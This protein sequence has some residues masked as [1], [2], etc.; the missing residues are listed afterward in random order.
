MKCLLPLYLLVLW[1]I[2]IVLSIRLG[3]LS[4]FE[5]PIWAPMLCKIVWGQGSCFLAICYC[6]SYVLFINALCALCSLIYS[7]LCLGAFISPLLYLFI[8]F[9]FIYYGYYLPVAQYTQPY[10]TQPLLIFGF[11]NPQNP[12]L[13]DF[14]RL[15]IKHNV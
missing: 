13:Y 4:Y 5:D 12:A 11:L 2:L 9:S 15:W 3:F 6:M 8:S 14:L 1:L 10:L 7:Y